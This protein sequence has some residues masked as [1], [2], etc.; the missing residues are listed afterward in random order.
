MV[1]INAVVP[2]LLLTDWG[3]RYSTEEIKEWKDKSILK[4]E[5]DLDDC[6][7]MYVT[8]AKNTSMTGQEVFVGKEFPIL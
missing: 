3:E 5:V 4:N 6:A 7:D 8:I 2:G 1:R